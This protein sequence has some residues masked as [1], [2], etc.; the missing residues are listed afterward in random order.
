MNTPARKGRCDE[1][2]GVIA[3]KSRFFENLGFVVGLALAIAY[4]M[5]VKPGPAEPPAWAVVCIILTCIAPKLVG[6]ATSGRVWTAIAN[7]FGGP[8]P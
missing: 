1:C 3:P 7:R 4:V 5:G 6:R 8:K 2:G